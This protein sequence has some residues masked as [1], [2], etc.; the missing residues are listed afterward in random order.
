MNFKSVKRVLYRPSVIPSLPSAS[1]NFVGA[2]RPNDLILQHHRRCLFAYVSIRAKHSAIP[3][4]YEHTLVTCY[5]FRRKN[6]VDMRYLR[7][8]TSPSQANASNL[9]PKNEHEIKPS[10]SNSTTITGENQKSS[11]NKAWDYATQL[12]SRMFTAVKESTQSS[13]KWVGFQIASSVQNNVN[14]IRQRTQTS[15]EATRLK[16]RQR[17]EGFQ[18]RVSSDIRNRTQSVLHGLRAPF[19]Y[20]W[21][22]VAN[23]WRATPIWNRFFWWSLSAIAVYGLATTIPKEVIKLAIAHSTTPPIATKT[24]STTNSNAS[25]LTPKDVEAEPEE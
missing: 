21:T 4:D 12:S 20:G 1:T 2:G 10:N 13:M 5:R 11:R 16:A 18:S 8:S 3:I 14:Q 17:M 24:T 6:N 9:N 23:A 15:I 7:T 22:Y 19:Q 25:I